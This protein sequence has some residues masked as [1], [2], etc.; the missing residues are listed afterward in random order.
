MKLKYITEDEA[1]RWRELPGYAL[2]GARAENVQ[3]YADSCTDSVAEKTREIAE[4]RAMGKDFMVQFN[5]QSIERDKVCR[6][7]VLAILDN[8]TALGR[9]EVDD[10]VLDAAR[11]DMS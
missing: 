9:V 8:L 10:E 5:L 1:R 3:D 4:W 2:R 11:R 6:E 7:F